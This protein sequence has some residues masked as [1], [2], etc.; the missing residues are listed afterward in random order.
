MSP[1]GY[2]RWS[3]SAGRFS[4]F[5]I[6]CKIIRKKIKYNRYGDGACFVKG[7]IKQCILINQ[8]P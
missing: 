6:M 2:R 7:V 1:V 5:P 3:E 8:L 4:V